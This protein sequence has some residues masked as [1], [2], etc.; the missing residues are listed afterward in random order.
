MWFY[1]GWNHC[2]Y[3]VCQK[4]N[5]YHYTREVTVTTSD[6]LG[7]NL[8]EPHGGAW[9]CQKFQYVIETYQRQGEGLHLLGLNCILGMFNANLNSAVSFDTCSAIVSNPN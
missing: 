7:R 6:S 4:K 2:I 8:I 9:V 3:G 1:D 5:E